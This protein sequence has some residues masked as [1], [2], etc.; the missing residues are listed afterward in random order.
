MSETMF[1]YGFDVLL[2]DIIEFKDI[3]LDLSIL[4]VYIAIENGKLSF[5]CKYYFTNIGR[6]LF[7]ITLI[8]VDVAN[9]F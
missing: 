1:I 4:L 9:Q 6:I 3:V 7:H 5:C 8:T 2:V